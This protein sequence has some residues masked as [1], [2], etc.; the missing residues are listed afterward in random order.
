MGMGPVV[1]VDEFGVVA[2]FYE[3]GGRA[4]HEQLIIS[5]KLSEC[6]P[7]R[8]AIQEQVAKYTEC[9]DGCLLCEVEAACRI[10]ATL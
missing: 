7:S 2:I 3:L 4:V 5:K 8:L 6:L 10:I 9:T 1:V